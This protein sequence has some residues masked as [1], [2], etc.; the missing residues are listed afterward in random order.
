MSIAPIKNQNRKSKSSSAPFLSSHL[1]LGHLEFV[2]DQR[3]GELHQFVRAARIKDRVRQVM[4]LFLH[5]GGVDAPAPPGPY[6][7]RMQPGASD[8][9]VEVSIL[10]GQLTEFV[11]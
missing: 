8:K 2:E 9:K 6:V 10:N 4:R 5:P 1:A 11:V 7:L 3:F